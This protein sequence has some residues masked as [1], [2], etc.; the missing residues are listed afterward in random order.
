MV[1]DQRGATFRE[2]SLAYHTSLEPADQQPPD[3]EELN[4]L[5]QNPPLP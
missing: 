1:P 3:R 4:V 5:L 2:A